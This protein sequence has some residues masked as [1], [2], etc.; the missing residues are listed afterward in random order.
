VDELVQPGD[1]EAGD[2][3]ALP[4]DDAGRFR[5]MA[6]RLGQGGFIVR[7]SPADGPAAGIERDVTL[8]V[9]VRLRR[10]G[11]IRAL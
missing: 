6:M 5:V 4:D 7:I 10:Y 8:T 2:V 9:A 1:L 3:I 11:R